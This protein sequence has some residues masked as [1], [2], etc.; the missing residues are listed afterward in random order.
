MVQPAQLA[1]GAEAY[2][3]YPYLSCCCCWLPCRAQECDEQSGTR[4]A[5]RPDR[6]TINRLVERAQAAGRVEVG[7]TA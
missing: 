1:P 2:P 4:G 7:L 3:T 5:N 6:K